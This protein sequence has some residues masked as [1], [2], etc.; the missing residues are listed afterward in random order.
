MKHLDLE[1]ENL[2]ERVAPGLVAGVSTGVSIGVGV[3]A[4]GNIGVSGGSGDDTHETG[5]CG[6]DSH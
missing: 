1:L 2:E 6:C 5:T 3:V 4:G